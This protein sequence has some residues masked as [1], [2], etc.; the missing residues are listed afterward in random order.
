M[1]YLKLKYGVFFLLLISP[2]NQLE[3]QSIN[4]RSTGYTTDN[5]GLSHNTVL[6]VYQD[7][8][9]FLWIGTMDGLNRFD[10]QKFEIYRHNPADS[11]TLSDS[12]IHGIFER[13]DGMLWV[14]TRD[15]GYNILNPFT[16]KITR[17]EHREDNKYEVP[18][19]PANL[20][21]EDSEGF[22]WIGFFASSMGTFDDETQKF[23]PTILELEITDE[24]INSVNHILELND[25]SF[26]FFGLSGLFY[27][28]AIEIERFRLNPKD[29]TPLQTK[30]IPFSASNPSPETN[31]L[32][33]DREGQLWCELVGVGFMKADINLF[34]DTVIRSI[35]T[36]VRIS[37]SPNSV[38]EKDDYILFGAGGGFLQQIN[39][40]TQAR[41]EIKVTGQE[42][43]GTSRIFT[44]NNDNIWFAS[45]GGGLL[46]LE[47]QKGI[48]H[49]FSVNG[50][51]ADFTLAFADD[52]D[53]A[54]IGTSNGL[55]YLTDQGQILQFDNIQNFENQSI[56]SLWKDDLG[57][58]I[59]TRFGGLFFISEESIQSGN[60]V[61][62]NFNSANSLVPYNDVHQVIRDSRGWL[63]LGYQGN[64][65]QIVKN[66]EAWLNGSPADLQMLS[67]ES[68][69]PTINSKSIRKIYEDKDGNIW[70]ATTDNGFNYIRFDGEQ[71][72]DISKFEYQPNSDFTLSHPDG[73]S[74]Y[75]QNDSTF[76]FASYGGG[77]TRWRS[78]SNTLQN[79][80]TNDGLANN[81]VYGILPDNNE[82]FIWASTNNGLSRLD[83]ESLRFTNFTT[84][85]GLQNNEFN[86]G[87]FLAKEDG[88]LLFGG[89]GG[90]NLIDTELLSIDKTEPPIYISAINVFNSPLN[91]DSSALYTNQLTLPYDQNFLSFEFSA[92]DLSQPQYVQFAYKLDG[93]DDDWV[94]SGN[95]N[96]AEYPNLK[97]GKFEFHVKA[98]NSDGYWN[99]VGTD[100]TLIITPPWWQTILFRFL[101]LS[102]ILA[103]FISTI[104]YYSQRWLKEQIRKMEIDQKLRNERERISRDLHDHV[105][106]QL[107]N[108]M[109]GL[110]LVDKYNEFDEKEKSAEMMQSLKGDAEVTIKQLRETIWAL[111][112]NE[113]NV[114]DFSDHLRSYFNNQSALTASLDVN[115]IVNS[116]N[117]IH[118]SATQALNVFRII[119]EAS[120]NTLKYA[121]AKT[122]TIRLNELNGGLDVSIVDDG[123]FK[124]NGSSFNG[125]YGTTNMQK[126]A[127]EINADVTIDTENGTKIELHVPL[128]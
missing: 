124:S 13:S 14:G 119:Q 15:G 1:G 39:K 88:R 51:R 61:A 6:N 9:G 111:N 121:G 44:D 62:Q 128:Q 59:S 3:A 52:V 22:F 99:E 47:E 76:W 43:T 67:N 116:E 38:I 106:A 11:T 125:G 80:R 74:I 81:S 109:S 96:F 42:M 112:Q 104:R 54:W 92:L 71:V 8:R 31:L 30:R 57:L 123:T 127:R 41:S 24:P 115:I 48:E 100:L 27:L 64:G 2:F 28:P 46:L 113:L 4:F 60:L 34:P 105:G 75:Q 108:I 118:L 95:R 79:F 94:Y 58:W 122:L 35:E 66:V 26:I 63:W 102:V 85:D 68:P 32:Y 40:R 17:I 91:S 77:I 78:N 117:D 72:S 101:A 82:R 53:G 36:G 110:S 45:W 12:F 29:K 120:Q 33:V 86:T 70:V 7:S 16:D 19:R 93:V 103:L 56:W 21:F 5:S 73:R 89:V 97:P 84:A 114:T 65:I 83:T 87:A 126:R 18:N 90:F 50:L 23:L 98:S 107:A 37:S 49:Y 10:G 69:E 20:M 55:D 25:G